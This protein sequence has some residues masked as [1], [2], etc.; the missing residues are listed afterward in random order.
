MKIGG[1]FFLGEFMVQYKLHTGD[2]L[3]VL[4]TLPDNSI[5]SVVTDPPYE[6][7]FM[8]KGWDKSGIANNVELWKE[9]F[10]VLKPGGHL[11]S[12]GGS[13]TYHRMASA[14]EDAGFE[15]R[16]QIQW[17]YGSGF[18][19]SHNISKAIDK[20][21]GVEAEVVGRQKGSLPTAGRENW[22]NL[23][24]R[25]DGKTPDGR[26]YQK[27]VER[28]ERIESEGIPLT[29]P[30]SDEAKKWDGWGTALKPAH[31]PIVFARKPI[32]GSVA[33]N[34]LQWGTGALNI[35][36][37]RVEYG[38]ES[39][40]TIARYANV[41]APSSA[42]P[43]WVHVNRGGRFDDSAK[44]SASLGRWPANILFDEE[45]AELLDEQSGVSKSTQRTGKR[46]GKEAGTFGKYI[47]QDEVS[48]GHSDSGG[49]SRFFYVAK[50]SPSERE[51]G[52][53]NMP[54]VRGGGMKGT[55]DGSLLTG[56]GNERNAMRANHHP[57]V[58]PITLMRYLVRLITPPD[59]IVLDPF[60]GSGTTGCATLMEGFS[61]IGID[62]SQEYN[63]IAEAR[64]KHWFDKGK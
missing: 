1:D 19:K 28:R 4:K 42:Q 5:D 33:D 8:D 54:L 59:G 7:G 31:E 63:D 3:E 53:E 25:G 34:V 30:T 62:L 6:L 39:N 11:L 13:R 37:S 55:E 22:K 45:A 24:D 20:K 43:D 51:A 17:I 18:P 27:A 15:I 60:S 16:D 52:L 12:F 29:V 23:Y 61:Y 36:G 41:N 2:S 58:K 57:T 48:M 10:R 21:L 26:D 47:G 32:K 64:M 40:P 49:A 9:V 50:A 44:Q 38:D 46:S 35:D 56:S 14:I